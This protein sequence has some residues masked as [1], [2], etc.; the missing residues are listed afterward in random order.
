MSA[1]FDYELTFEQWEA[2]KSLRLPVP[3]SRRLNGLVVD[4]LIAATRSDDRRWSGH[5]ATRPQGAGA[6]FVAAVVGSRSLRSGA[7]RRSGGDGFMITDCHFFARHCATR[8]RKLVIS[9][10]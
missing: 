4:G 8:C 7:H 2:L 6:R 1:E 5:Y 10:N 9:S 3:R